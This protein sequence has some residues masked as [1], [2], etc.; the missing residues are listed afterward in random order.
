MAML[1]A[2]R[3]NSRGFTKGRRAF[4]LV[5]L[6]VVIVIIST[7]ALVAVPKFSNQGRRSKEAM[8]RSNLRPL[9]NAIHAFEMDTER[10][11][12]TL[13]DLAATTAPANGL[14]GGGNVKP[15]DPADWNGPY[16]E[17]VDKDPVSGAP[18][19]YLTSPPDTGKVRS[20]ATGN[21]LDGTAYSTW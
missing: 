13:A 2:T 19:L 18:F 17:R 1:R 21:G 9:R 8:L 14:N 10:F 6:L 11:L 3:I 20:S 12:A 4:T 15:I 5:E 7:L 16:L